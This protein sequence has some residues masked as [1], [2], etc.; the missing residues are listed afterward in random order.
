MARGEP[1][2][3]SARDFEGVVGKSLPGKGPFKRIVLM[4]YL[5]YGFF[6]FLLSM[7]TPLWLFLLITAL[8]LFGMGSSLYLQK[9]MKLPVGKFGSR[10]ELAVK[11]RKKLK[12][13]DSKAWAERRKFN[14]VAVSLEVSYLILEE[15]PPKEPDSSFSDHPAADSLLPL[16]RRFKS[17]QTVIRDISEGGLLIMSE[18][19]FVTGERLK[20]SVQLPQASDPITILAEVRSCRSS[21]KPGKTTYKAGLRI[22]DLDLEEMVHLLDYLFSQRP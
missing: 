6:L 8:S 19:P 1:Q 13:G 21:F 4:V 9:N 3:N 14:R 22:L 16:T 15:R 12:G 2:K 11:S 10:G 18:E 20:L 17:G 5:Y 7:T